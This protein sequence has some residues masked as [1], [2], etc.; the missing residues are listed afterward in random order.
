[1]SAVAVIWIGVA[2]VCC[3]LCIYGINRAVRRSK[4]RKE[5]RTRALTGR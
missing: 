3:S 2:A 1:M 4:E 5:G